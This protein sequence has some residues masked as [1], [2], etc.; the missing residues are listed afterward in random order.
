MIKNRTIIEVEVNGRMFALECASES[1]WEEV[2][3]SLT[4]IYELALQK[5]EAAKAQAEKQ[6]EVVEPI[7]EE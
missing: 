3:K 5:Q 1:T 7:K 2:I 6:K 4:T